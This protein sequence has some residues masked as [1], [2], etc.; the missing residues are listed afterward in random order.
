MQQTKQKSAATRNKSIIVTI[1]YFIQFLFHSFYFKTRTFARLFHEKK[2]NIHLIITS[3]VFLRG[4]FHAQF[5]CEMNMP[6]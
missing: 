2:R 3:C 5:R 4:F 1:C 6:F